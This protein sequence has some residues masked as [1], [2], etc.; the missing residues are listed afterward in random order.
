M[1]ELAKKLR[2][3]NTQGVI[4][5]CSLYSTREEANARGG[6]LPLVVDGIPCYAALGALNEEEAT[7]GRQEKNGVR[8]AIL[9]RGTL[10]PGSIT[11]NFSQSSAEQMFTVPVGV[12]VI[13]VS[14]KD[15]NPDTEYDADYF[16]M[17]AVPGETLP[18]SMS[19]YGV[20]ES[21]ENPWGV[22]GHVGKYEFYFGD[23]W[24]MILILSWS[25]AINH[26]NAKAYT[27]E[28]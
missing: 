21:E 28:G 16:Y 22:L 2:I 18:V 13:R 25:E 11:Y 7:R 15:F 27:E 19:Q 4:E 20:S 6:V 10:P 5:V 12:K 9:K 1:A 8:M 24:P 23:V 3:Q 26:H 14:S 17:P